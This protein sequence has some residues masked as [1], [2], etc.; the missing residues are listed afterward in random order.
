MLDAARTEVGQQREKWLAALEREQRDARAGD[1]GRARPLG[2]R[3]R[4]E[5][6]LAAR[7]RATRAPSRRRLPAAPRDPA[8]EVPRA[9]RS[10]VQPT[11]RVRIRA[12]RSRAHG[13]L[14]RLVNALGTRADVTF[15]RDHAIVCGIE[16]SCGRTQ[17]RLAS[18]GLRHPDSRPGCASAW[19]ALPRAG[20]G[21]V[22]LPDLLREARADVETALAAEP[23]FAPREKGTVIHVGGGIAEIDGLPSLRSRR[24]GRISVRSARHRRESRAR[25]CRH[26]VARRDARRSP[27]ARKC[28]PRAGSPIRQSAPASS[29]ACVDAL[30]RPLD[31]KGPV[32]TSDAL[33]ARTAPRPQSWPARRSRCRSRPGS[34]SIDDRHPDRTGTA[35]A[36]SRRPADR[37]D[38]DRGGH[39]TQPARWRVVCVYC[40]IGQRG[41]AVARVIETLESHGALG[42]R[43]VVVGAGDDP[44]GLQFI[45]PYA[46]TTMAEYFMQQGQD[47]LIV[48]DD[49]TRHARVYR[50]LSLLL[51]RPP[52]REAYP[53]D[54]FYIHS[55]LLER[56][57]QL[58]VEHG[59]R[60]PHGAADRRDP[61]AGHL[62]LHP[63]QSDLDYGRSDLCLAGALPEVARF[64]RSTSANRSRASAAKRNCRPTGRSPAHCGSPTPSSRS[65]RRSRASRRVSTMPRVRP[66]NAAGASARCSS[67]PSTRLCRRPSKSRAARGYLGNTRRTRTRSSR[68]VRAAR[69][70]GARRRACS[71]ASRF[72]LDRMPDEED[73]Q[74]LGTI[75]LEAA[76]ALTGA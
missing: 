64:R 69:L 8:A 30:G 15:E 17:A 23:L 37:E 20:S 28:K 70:R 4:K 21:P 76:D 16:L 68:R 43:V 25:A 45:T 32:A 75:A 67:K 62:G 26:R 14:H 65:W 31:G 10:G 71:T 12:G 61:S 5:R 9:F 48:Y 11:H 38:D 40:A 35:R 58:K 42:A 53:G 18:R 56:A 66:S 52:G 72:A 19:K 3:N 54:I 60:F 6:T 34:R 41:T 29:A 7:G 59:W 55:R 36:D 73:W 44:A 27:R 47:V 2:Q 49:L 24:A 74:V 22:M 39:D 51:R 46:A 13:A 33:A 63:D 50:E 57:T 1:S